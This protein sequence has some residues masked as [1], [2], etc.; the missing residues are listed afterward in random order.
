MR[1]LIQKISQSLKTFWSKEYEVFGANLKTKDLFLAGI[2]SIVIACMIWAVTHFGFFVLLGGLWGW[3]KRKFA[4]L[5][6]TYLGL[7]LVKR[8][9]IDQVFKPII[10]RYIIPHVG[11]AT[12]LRFIELWQKVRLGIKIL[13]GLFMGL[14][15]GL[16]IA[17]ASGF[18]TL[19][20]IL[21]FV[22]TKVGIAKIFSALLNGLFWLK[23][24]PF[25]GTPLSFLI[26][27]VIY[28]W[29]IGLIERIIP[30]SWIR[31]LEPLYMRMK[32]TFYWIAQFFEKKFGTHVESGAIWFS[33]KIW[34]EYL[35][36]EELTQ[37]RKKEIR[38]KR[39]EKRKK[40]K[41][42]ERRL[43][44]KSLHIAR[45]RKQR[46]LKN[47]RRNRNWYFLRRS[48]IS[49]PLRWGRLILY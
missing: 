36:P 31:K 32:R 42:K 25:I 48:S 5:T 17:L 4:A 26:N 23:T 6:W 2:A 27:V 49:L 7:G 8:Y 39:V 16:Y 21:T 40:Q 46:L 47:L 43:S 28:S 35:T 44:R 13:I 41:Q 37:N 33:K 11:L 18:K 29:I 34:R 20:A 30:K 24:L 9:V 3:T 19:S 1:K 38:K 14:F 12:K 22:L 15:G 45:L 10:L